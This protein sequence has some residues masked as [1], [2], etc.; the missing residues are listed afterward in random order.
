MPKDVCENLVTIGIMQ[1]ISI[2]AS[3]FDSFLER[4]WGAIFSAGFVDEL[5]VTL[6][7][8][9]TVQKRLAIKRLPCH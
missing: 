2:K 9:K 3:N 8:M 5:M 4:I 1:S 7:K 6:R